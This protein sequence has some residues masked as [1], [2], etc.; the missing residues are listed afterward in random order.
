[1][2]KPEFDRK[3]PG[4]ASTF[5]FLSEDG[6]QRSAPRKRSK[7]KSVRHMPIIRKPVPVSQSGPLRAPKPGDPVE[8]PPPLTTGMPS[9]EANKL[10][11]L[12]QNTPAAASSKEASGKVA[13]PPDNVRP[14][15]KTKKID[16]NLDLEQE[17]IDFG[18]KKTD[19]F[20]SD[21]NDGITAYHPQNDQ[22]DRGGSSWVI[23]SLAFLLLAGAG[24]YLYATGKLNEWTSLFTDSPQL[25]QTNDLSEPTT[26][27]AINT[28]TDIPVTS[29]S[30]LSV[31]FQ[32]QL[33]ILQTLLSTGALD[34]AEEAL[35]AMDRTVYGYGAAEF[36]DIEA[37]IGER[38]VL[39]SGRGVVNEQENAQRL[40]Q[41]RL[42]GLEV[43][44]Q[45]EARLAQL[46]AEEALRLE[47]QRIREQQARE[48]A[49]VEQARLAREAD[50]AA[51]LETARLE[52]EAAEEAQR[53]ERQRVER[54]AAE[55]ARAEELRLERE[56]AEYARLE[57]IREE[58][59][60]AREREQAREAERL[61]TL[62]AEAEA[63]RIRIAEEQARTAARI[64]AARIEQE[65]RAAEVARLEQARLVEQQAARLEAQRLA[66][67][68]AEL[69]AQQ[70][71]A[72]RVA[73]AQA[74]A[75]AAE[76]AAQRE[77]E[78]AAARAAAEAEA[79]R[80]AQLEQSR[81]AVE[82]AAARAD[83][84]RLDAL[85]EVAREEARRQI[86]EADR[87]ATD[88]RIAEE[89][90]AAERKAS[91]E[92]RLIRAREIEAANAA[93]ALA[94]K[95]SLENQA[96]NQVAP[97]QQSRGTVSEINSSVPSPTVNR[98]ITDEELQ[99]VY[100]K[101]TDLQN[102]I[103]SRDISQVVSL[104]ER[105][106]IRV[107]QFMQVFENSAGIDVRIR[108]VSTSNASGEIVGTLQISSIVR[109]DGS[110]AAP[111]PDLAS[112]RVTSNRVGSNWSSIRW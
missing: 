17:F 89:R 51:R 88:R 112:I 15:R 68:R 27:V 61:A 23:L 5:D 100:K 67:Q 7:K 19:D 55:A 97:S 83:R 77:R 58:Q 90:A 22:D 86:T 63:E 44:R 9:K 71:E 87:L 54:E 21:W 31:R 78:Q 8:P 18:R 72:Q 53:L 104:T 96:K 42:A 2:S 92:Q 34:E 49:Q 85:E 11:F 62:K 94:E 32:D 84:I 106:G 47:Q 95:T 20:G 6:Q 60:L 74:Q 69:A 12:D 46:R 101:F 64:E 50:E 45:E 3:K 13:T 1:M 38:R 56:A 66:E 93:A 33:A 52:R 35:A 105:S 25:A 70:R 109:N 30:P 79:A 41:E 29:A 80:Q 82:S 103:R 4:K 107:Q 10:D 75:R 110:L 36:A 73:E 57:Q 98:T 111:P 39:A 43:A 26:V 40:E 65:A 91:R 108:N 59:R 24:S 81:T 14:L 28:E 16:K 102:A 76:I 99:V 37:R 48:A